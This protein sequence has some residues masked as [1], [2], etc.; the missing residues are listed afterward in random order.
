MIMKGRRF[1]TKEE[2][3]INSLDILRSLTQQVSLVGRKDGGDALMQEDHTSK[4]INKYLSLRKASLSLVERLGCESTRWLWESTRT[5]TLSRVRFTS[6]LHQ[7]TLLQ[8]STLSCISTTLKQTAKMKRN[9]VT[10]VCDGTHQDSLLGA[11]MLQ[12]PGMLESGQLLEENHNKE[13][14]FTSLTNL[15][16]TTLTYLT[17]SLQVEAHKVESLI[18]EEVGKFAEELGHQSDDQLPQF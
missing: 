2:I 13:C 4:I 5:R 8:I 9:T 11:G 17:Q 7:T 16:L 12:Q 15:L 14:I 1:D 18:Q 6:G 10:K 3:K